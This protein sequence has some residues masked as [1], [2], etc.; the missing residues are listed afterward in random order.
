[1]L[2]GVTY[3]RVDDAGL[4]IEQEDGRHVL[5]VDHVVVCAGQVEE[6]GIVEDL[7]SLG[8]DVHVIGGA[9]LAAELDAKRAIRQGAEVAIGL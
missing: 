2:A 3:C 6:V 9:A 4:H 5:E 1:M 7:R 8:V